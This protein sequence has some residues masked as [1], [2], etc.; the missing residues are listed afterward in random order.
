MPI[1]SNEAR[2]GIQVIARAASVLRALKAAP[3]GLSLGQI[4]E[5]VDL[6]RSTVQRIVAA[7]EAERLVI[8]SN[9][10]S[11]IRLG[12][13]IGALAEAARFN[14]AE[15]VKPLLQDLSEQSGETVDLSVLRGNRM[16]F[17]DQITSSQRLV[18][19]SS[20][21]EAFTL[22]DTANGKACLARM[23][24]VQIG[25]LA[26]AEW[27]E[28]GRDGDIERLMA[29]IASIRNEG[30]SY[31]ENEHTPG[32]SAMGIGFADWKGDFYAISIPAPTSRFVKNREALRCA[33]T[34]IQSTVDG[35]IAK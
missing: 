27:A 10:Y 7:L 9:A 24:D 2:S 23:S 15:L 11:G 1:D 14:V 32:I 13:E 17:I 18:A 5:K 20:V 6:P 34:G 35:M 30:V 21:G 28:T 25:R 26:R 16:I 19:M 33:L 31:D 3:A 4:A 8:A 22:T 29:G 12:P